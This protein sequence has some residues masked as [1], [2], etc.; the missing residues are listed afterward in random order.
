M[1][2]IRFSVVIPTYNRATLIL[3][4]LES[5]FL[6]RYRNFEIIV[7]DNHSSDNTEEVLSPLVQ[8]GRIR[9]IRHDQNYERSKSRNTGLQHATGDYVTF[10]DS[11]DFLYPDC[12]QDAAAYATAHPDIKVFHNKYELV[13]DRREVVYRFRFPSLNNQYKALATGNFLSCIGGFIHRDIYSNIR[14]N[15]DPRMI[16]SEDY[17]IWFDILAQHKVGR[18]DKI[19]AGIRE[20]PARSVHTG[21][22]DNIAYQKAYLIEKIKKNQVLFSSFGRYLSVLESSFLLQQAIVANQLKNKTG[23]LG[24]V[25]EALMKNTALIFSYR[26]YGVIYN[27]LKP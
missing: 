6:Q 17:E 26:F 27:I 3:E 7:V 11:D 22:Y 2:P 20:H 25:R 1:L 5:V 18:I 21:V 8:T 9:Y 10:L 24:F 13:N 16:G 19:N 12:L 14:F 4:T 23:A 15:E